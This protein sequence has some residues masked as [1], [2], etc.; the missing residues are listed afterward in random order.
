MPL[1]N[2]DKEFGDFLTVQARRRQLGLVIKTASV[3]HDGRME[4]IRL[5][6]ASEGLSKTAAG[7]PLGAL[8]SIAK[9]S[10]GTRALVGAGVGGATEAVR[11]DGNIARG[12]LIGAGLGAGAG[13][14]AGFA[15]KQ[16]LFSRLGAKRARTIA[17]KAT[18]KGAPVVPP[19]VS[20]VA[21]QVAKKG[22]PASPAVRKMPE[23][24]ASAARML[25]RPAVPP[26]VVQASF[27][28]GFH[29]EVLQKM[30][31]KLPLLPFLSA[32]TLPFAGMGGLLGAVASKKGERG[33]GA[34][35]GAI[36]GG[37]VGLA[38]G[39]ALRKAHEFDME[40]KSRII[41]R[42]K[43]RVLAKRRFS[44]AV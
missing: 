23:W 19:V 38:G 36:I 5:K 25:R 29:D 3:V 33:R 2:I 22:T 31:R 44:R 15:R 9:S 7:V 11:G 14:A 43:N 4:A 24:L 27:E 20:K 30:A 13:P 8:R 35:R 1:D 41:K 28:T 16:M 39:L 6:Q 26:A 10:I 21:P 17:G 18:A 12:A 37:G 32:T 40:D 42:L 34:L